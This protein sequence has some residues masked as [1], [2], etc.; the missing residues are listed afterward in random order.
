MA[1]KLTSRLQYRN[2]HRVLT[3]LFYRHD[4]IGLAAMGAPEDEYEAEVSTVIPRLKDA[5]GPDDVRRIV[6]QEFL[7]WF[8]TE[9]TAG[10]E[11]G[12]N[13][14]AKDIWN[15]LAEVTSAQD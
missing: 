13:D 2:L 1:P 5:N 4:P 7:R 14:L 6:Y 15:K 8:G 11:S 3:E 12:Y 10:P 9:E